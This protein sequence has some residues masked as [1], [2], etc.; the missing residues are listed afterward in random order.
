[1]DKVQKEERDRIKYDQIA[2]EKEFETDYGE[3]TSW[4][5]GW[6]QIHNLGDFFKVFK[7]YINLYGIFL[8]YALISLTGI[9]WNVYVNID[10]NVGWAG[11]NLFL[12]QGTFYMIF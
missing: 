3:L 2:I 9:V 5:L 11:G 6:S 8:P 12:M 10:W 4:K 7:Y 1:M